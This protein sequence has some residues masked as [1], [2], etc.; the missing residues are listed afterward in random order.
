MCGQ[1]VV[2]LDDRDSAVVDIQALKIAIEKD[3]YYLWHADAEP[4][5]GTPTDAVTAR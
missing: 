4:A 1:I 2:G 3:G 5:V